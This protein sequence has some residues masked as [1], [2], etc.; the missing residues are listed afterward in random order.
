MTLAPL[1][2]VRG[3]F[4]MQREASCHPSVGDGPS[5]PL[6]TRLRI[7]RNILEIANVI[8]RADELNRP[9]QRRYYKPTNLNSGYR[10]YAANEKIGIC[11]T[12]AKRNRFP[13]GEAVERSETDE[14]RRNRAI[15]HAVRKKV[16]FEKLY[17]LIC[18]RPISE[19]V[20]VPHPPLRGTFPPGEGI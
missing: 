7:R 10:L 13:R 16:R 3:A 4:V 9:L 15:F 2:K 12:G 18:L 11:L 20:A 8:L 14:E 6:R 1:T 5:S 17:V 19:N